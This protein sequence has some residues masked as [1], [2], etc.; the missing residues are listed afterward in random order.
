MSSIANRKYTDMRQIE[1]QQSGSSRVNAMLVQPLLEKSST[2]MCEVTDLQCS[3]GEELAFPED[4]W[5][6]SIVTRPREPNSTTFI[7]LDELE[8]WIQVKQRI[9]REAAEPADVFFGIDTVGGW[10]PGRRLTDPG[11]DP[12]GDP[13]EEDIPDHLRRVYHVYSR[14]HY[15]VMDFVHDVC[16][17]VKQI[18]RLISVIANARLPAN[19]PDKDDAKYDWAHYEEEKQHNVS[20]TFDS[21]GRLQFN[22]KNNFMT[23]F[24]IIVSPLFQQVSG[25][26]LF[27]GEYS[28]DQGVA[29]ELITTVEQFKIANYMDHPVGVYHIFELQ[30]RNVPANTD[31]RTEVRDMV[32]VQVGIDIRKKLILEVSLPISHTLAWD[33]TRES[34]KYVLQEFEFPKEQLELGYEGGPDY[35]ST[36]IRYKEK[37]AHGTA[38]FLNGGSNLAVKKLQEG[39]MQAFRVDLILDVAQWNAELGQFARV[40]RPLQ[41]G[42]GGF[43]YLKLLFTK[44]TI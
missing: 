6:F 10:I 29:P 38:S 25:F 13:V 17:Q 18:D 9:G 37:V 42:L 22:L 31:L 20:L 5:L 16:Q 35:N 39:Q 33:G 21:G 3:V 26:P 7:N 43:F 8:D 1:F 44:E 14:R 28:Q 32:P 12:G 4:Q 36:K 40:R 19:H 15:S 24:M 30:D 2:Y 41:I 11:G 34:T 23:N 27:I